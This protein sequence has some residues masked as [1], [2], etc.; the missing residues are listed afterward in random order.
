MS[1]IKYDPFKATTQ[2]MSN[3]AL[4][5][6]YQPSDFAVLLHHERELIVSIPVRMDDGTV[7]IF[8]GYRIQHSSSRG[9]CKGGIRFHPQV[10]HNQVRALSCWMSLKCAVVNIP[11][12]GAKGG[13]T[14]DPSKL[15]KGELERLTRR[16]TS[17]IM[18]IIGPKQDIPAP[19][20]N[21]N[22]EIMGW[23]MDTYSMMQG[24]SVP[25]VV[26]GKP[27]ELGGSLGRSAAT[28]R[29]VMIIAEE[30][31]KLLGMTNKQNIS[32]AIQG[33]GNV[34]MNAALL[35][36]GQGYKIIAMSDVSG[37]LYNESGLYVDSIR[38][39]VSQ[40]MLLSDYPL[41]DAKNAK[42]KRISNAEILTCAC[43]LLIP[44]ALENQITLDNAADVRA[45]I[46]V[47]AANGPITADA[48]EMLKARD[49]PVFPDILANAGGVV[50]S[51]FEWVQGS[52]RLYWTEEDVNEKLKMIMTRAF[53]EVVEMKEKYGET[54]RNGA[55]MVAMERLIQCKKY[56]GIFP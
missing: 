30:A 6:G 7:Q 55:L 49:I 48:D 38:D 52:T 41:D 16:Y 27:L 11:Y 26:T 24:Y 1:D 12:G 14:V 10:D 45:K 13:V 36:A 29:G 28:G 40:K 21:T 43:D 54:Y 33:S 35:M 46:I 50:V 56:R 25:D 32:V 23:I 15:S 9:P 8:E 22:S 44:A 47:E 20:V 37:G 19:D 4:K 2:N 51:Y 53:A 3:A 18:P 31:L 34:G 42:T 17:M 5:I 39:H